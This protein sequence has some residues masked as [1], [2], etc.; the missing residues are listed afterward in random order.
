MA[1]ACPGDPGP[2]EGPRFLTSNPPA[3][4]AGSGGKGLGRV[5]L[6]T[7]YGIE[8]AQGLDHAGYA[9]SVGYGEFKRSA[10]SAG[11]GW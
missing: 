4:C 9:D 11:P 1:G 5:P 6:P 3:E 8:F 2:A 10:Y 7:E